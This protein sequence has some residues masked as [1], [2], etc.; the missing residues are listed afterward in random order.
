MGVEGP[1]SPS[2]APDERGLK[3]LP[4][5]PGKSDA[6][7]CDDEE[8]FRHTGG[9]ERHFHAGTPHTRPA[10]LLVHLIL[11]GLELLP[12]VNYAKRKGIVKPKKFL[13]PC[14]ALALR[15]CSARGEFRRATHMR[16]TRSGGPPVLSTN[17]SFVNPSKHLRQRL[18]STVPICTGRTQIT[19]R[20]QMPH[21]QPPAGFSY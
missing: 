13:G 9:P 15:V 8:C 16:S 4:I 11:E 6:R 14:W 7:W 10:S 3:G 17:P 21:S 1:A 20:P 19:A 5:W 2:I 18:Y 12:R